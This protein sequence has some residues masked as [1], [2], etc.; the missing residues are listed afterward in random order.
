MIDSHPDYIY[1]LLQSLQTFS[2]SLSLIGCSITMYTMI[3]GKNTKSLTNNLLFYLLILD[4]VTSIFYAVGISGTINSDFCQLQ[5]LVVQWFG[6]AGIIWVTYMSFQMYQWIVRKLS[7]DRLMKYTKKHFLI[8]LAL[9]GLLGII[10]LGLG[11]YDDATIWCW[12]DQRRTDLRF[13]CFYLMLIPAWIFTIT[14]TNYVSLTLRKSIH[15]SDQKNIHLQMSERNIQRKL[16]RYVFIF[17]FTWFFPLLNRFLEL[18]YGHSVISTAILQAAILPLRG[19]LNSI[20]YGNVYLVIFD[21]LMKTIVRHRKSM[22]D[23]I[24]SYAVNAFDHNN[25][26]PVFTAANHESKVLSL[27]VTTLNFGEA[28][29][30]TI[31]KNMDEWI[32]KGHDVY[33]I[34]FQ[35]C[36]EINDLK[37]VILDYLGSSEYFGFHNEIGSGNTQLGYHGYIG[38][39]VFVRLSDLASG[40]VAPTSAAIGTMAT[41]TNLIVAKAQNKGAVGLAFQINDTS[42]AFVSCHLPSDSKGRSKLSKRNAS[43]QALLKELNL[44]P[45]DIG[46]DAHFQ[47]DH[48][49]V[50]GDFNYRMDTEHIGG[51]SGLLA[52]VASAC[53]LEKQTLTRGQE[54]HTSWL[55]KKYDLLRSRKDIMYPSEYEQRALLDAK[56]NSRSA[57]SAILSADELR[58]IMEGGDAFLGF[59]EPLPCFPPSYKRRKNHL[60]DCGDYTDIKLLLQGFSNIGQDH[61]LADGG[62]GSADSNAYIPPSS[63]SSTTSSRRI[64]S[65]RIQQ[66]SSSSSSAKEKRPSSLPMIGRIEDIASSPVAVDVVEERDNDVLD[67]DIELEIVEEGKATS[68]SPKSTPGREKKKRAALNN[69][70]L[71]KLNSSAMNN[72]ESK[73]DQFWKIRPPSYTDRILI[74]SLED[75]RSRVTVQ[76][77]DLCDTMRI[78]DHRPVCMTIRL[79]VNNNIKYTENAAE[80]YRKPRSGIT[81]AMYELSILNLTVYLGETFIEIPDRDGDQITEDGD[82]YTMEDGSVRSRSNTNLSQDQRDDFSHQSYLTDTLNAVRT[83]IRSSIGLPKSTAGAD[84]TAALNEQSTDS[85]HSMKRASNQSSGNNSQSDLEEA[86]FEKVEVSHSIPA[87]NAWRQKIE[88]ERLRQRKHD[89]LSCRIKKSLSRKMHLHLVKDKKTDKFVAELDVVFPLPSKDPLLTHRKIHAFAEALETNSSQLF[90]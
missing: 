87:D 73:K 68:P 11:S 67:G 57:W 43:A 65:A 37:Q 81:T 86:L 69:E 4:I 84:T 3:R 2:S 80:S 72:D 9:T 39:F 23:S 28:A 47:H 1:P 31:T 5:G 58:M 25:G 27:F 41:G 19:F 30:D 75:R 49:I 55:K 64:H 76:A 85:P 53:L 15:E 60:G 44:T 56:A 79:E 17:I 48:L 77:Y 13:F 12:I 35:E 29:F 66:P 83:A 6:L 90:K 51:S 82:D 63:S 62:S 61:L 18:I 33:A 52:A 46:Y 42:V 50:V 40:D 71:V 14:I 10:L 22:Q 20:V 78:S 26:V 36:L 8:I 59:F 24:T 34:G 38:L 54:I 16:G 88:E 45:D 32:V 7:P 74:Y 70:K 89:E 21:N